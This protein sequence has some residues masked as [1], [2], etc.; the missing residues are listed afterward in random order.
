MFI[1]SVISWEGLREV[2][3]GL[4]G[5]VGLMPLGI[6]RGSNQ[7]RHLGGFRFKGN[8]LG[9]TLFYDYM[10]PKTFTNAGFKFGKVWCLFQ[11]RT[12]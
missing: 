2:G 12:G 8:H 4:R 7:E 1:A 5:L 6:Q 9:E 10:Q 11:T 3:Q